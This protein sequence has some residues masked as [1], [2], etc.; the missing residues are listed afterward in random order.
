ML[1][2][3]EG[4]GVSRHIGTQGLTLDHGAAVSALA[5]PASR[6]V[7]WMAESWSQNGLLAVAR[8]A[9]DLI[10]LYLYLLAADFAESF[11]RLV[12]AKPCERPLPDVAPSVGHNDVRERLRRCEI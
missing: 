7:P 1:R 9:Q 4:S 8:G 11:I 10:T 12:N 3:L 6:S 2:K 5:A